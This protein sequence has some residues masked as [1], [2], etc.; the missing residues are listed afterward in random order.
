[1]GISASKGGGEENEFIVLE[2]IDVDVI[3]EKY[4]QLKSELNGNYSAIYNKG[5]GSIGTIT[6][7]TSDELPGTL[8][9][10]HIDEIN[11]IISGTFEFTV[12]DDDNNEIKI[13][14]G[15]FDLKY[16]N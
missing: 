14:N 2:G 1:M 11:G 7:A 13:T 6:V 9:I 16:T 4:Y 12:L 15:R 5:D 10:T 3:F 8:T